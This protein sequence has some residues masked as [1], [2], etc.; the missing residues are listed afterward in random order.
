[1]TVPLAAFELALGVESNATVGATVS[2]VNVR[3]AVQAE[4]GPIVSCACADQ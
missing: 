2:I 3:F 1:M 4:T